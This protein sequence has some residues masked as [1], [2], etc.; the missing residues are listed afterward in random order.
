MPAEVEHF[1]MA[2]GDS[3]IGYG[4]PALYQAF[5]NKLR[6]PLKGVSELPDR[7]LAGVDRLD[8]LMG[9]EQYWNG[10]SKADP[11]QDVWQCEWWSEGTLLCRAESAL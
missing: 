3:I 11:G 2:R 9:Q 7:L 1:F 10:V 6:Q 5:E 8:Q 4:V